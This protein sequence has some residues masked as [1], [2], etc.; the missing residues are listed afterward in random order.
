MWKITLDWDYGQTG[1]MDR[2]RPN[3]GKNEGQGVAEARLD[4]AA[5]ISNGSEKRKNKL[6]FL[7]M[8]IW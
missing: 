7:A 3:G 4:T 5:E 1:I 6:A 2:V 8:I